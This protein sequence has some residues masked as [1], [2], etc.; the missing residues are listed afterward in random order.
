M[1]GTWEGWPVV[2]SRIWAACV[3]YFHYAYNKRDVTCTVKLRHLRPLQTPTYNEH[4]II[5]DS[6]LCPWGEKP[7]NQPRSHVLSPTR[8][9]SLAP[10]GRRGE[11]P[12][13]E[14]ALTFSLNS[15][16]LIQALR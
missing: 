6:L 2:Y 4:L 1:K 9:L 10:W 8:S 3:S 15:T 12:W 16:R 13:N 7:L 5:T 14:V 11:N